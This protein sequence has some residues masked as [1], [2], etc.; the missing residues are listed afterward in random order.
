M[1][2]KQV[3]VKLSV[4]LLITGQGFTGFLL[5]FESGFRL[6]LWVDGS[7]TQEHRLLCL[8]SN[9]VFVLLYYVYTYLLS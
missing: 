7:D 9:G 2:G 6:W 1:A 8:L 3:G 4:A 5:Y